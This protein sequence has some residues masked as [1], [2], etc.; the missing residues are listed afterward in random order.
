MRH[1]TSFVRLII[2]ILMAA[3]IGTGIHLG[4]EYSVLKDKLVSNAYN[5]E[6]EIRALPVIGQMFEVLS[7]SLLDRLK[8]IAETSAEVAP[9]LESGILITQSGMKGPSGKIE[10][11]PLFK[12]NQ[13]QTQ[14]VNEA[15]AAFQKTVQTNPE[16][17]LE[18]IE[19]DSKLYLVASV[20]SSEMRASSRQYALVDTSEY[21]LPLR[22]AADSFHSSTR[23]LI[24]SKSGKVI[25][26]NLPAMIGADYTARLTGADLTQEA[27][28]EIQT[29]ESETDSKSLWILPVLGGNFYAAVEQVKSLPPP[30]LEQPEA[31]RFLI[32]LGVLSVILLLAFIIGVWGIL[33]ASVRITFKKDM[34]VKTAALPSSPTDK[35][36]S[37]IIPYQKKSEKIP[38]QKEDPQSPL[39]SI[40]HTYQ[41]EIRKLRNPKL[42]SP[43]LVETLS[44]I[45]Q[46]PVLFFQYNSESRK[47]Y[48]QAK[49]GF[50][51][52]I[53]LPFSLNFPMDTPT[54]N[55]IIQCEK[56]RKIASLATY[57]PLLKTVF[58]STGARQFEAWALTTPYNPKNPHLS[59]PLFIGVI[60]LTQPRLQN[61]DHRKSLIRLMRSTGAAYEESLL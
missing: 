14:R 19:V 38:A 9:R 57:T 45:T 17:S 55:G 32:K 25:F 36:G 31:L 41:K 30:M 8:S 26:H 54:L 53:S 61:P 10:L 47:A 46:S 16:N 39:Q 13:I 58:N 43:R 59:E 49:S 52:K 6:N 35:I 34:N 37:K 1:G 7:K 28:I 22:V 2:L 23:L 4:G 5:P 20:N 18:T 27:P 3:S 11:G 12:A 33:R 24:L 29:N 60:V 42:M 44:K 50:P 48:L 56:D 21:Y 51:S 40:V 15:I